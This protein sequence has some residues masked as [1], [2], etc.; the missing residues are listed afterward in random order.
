MEVGQWRRER[1]GGNSVFWGFGGLG[2]FCYLFS[3][4]KEN[5]V[6]H[7]HKGISEADVVTGNVH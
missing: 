7:I 6:K 2:V 1:A 4:Y 3:S 5:F